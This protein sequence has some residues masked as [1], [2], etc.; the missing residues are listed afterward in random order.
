MTKQQSIAK[1]T[2][3]TQ[4]Q[5]VQL[6]NDQVVEIEHLTAQLAVQESQ[7]ALNE[8]L[9]RQ[10]DELKAQLAAEKAA[11]KIKDSQIESLNKTVENQNLHINAQTKHMAEQVS[12]HQA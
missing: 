1:E 11:S 3:N 4:A 5:A 9:Q 2:V 12:L 6:M 8:G 10:I 7:I